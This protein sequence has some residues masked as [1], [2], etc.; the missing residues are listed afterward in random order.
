[1]AS[2]CERRVGY[3]RLVGEQAY[4]QLAEV[5]R[6]LRLYV[7]CFQPS[8]KL[9]AKQVVER[10]IHRTYD[11]AN[12]LCNPVTLPGLVQSEAR[13]VRQAHRL[14]ARLPISPQRLLAWVYA[15]ACLAASWSL[16]DGTAPQH[17]L[18]MAHLV[19]PHVSQDLHQ[20]GRV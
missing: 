4:Q 20:R 17:W 2:W 7:N 12:V 18:R 14:A 5:Y 8:M 16:E 3:G 10:K 9:V 19:R 1:M 11:A 13:L 6:A 15:H